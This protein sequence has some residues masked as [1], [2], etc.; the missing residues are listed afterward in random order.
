MKTW[1]FAKNREKTRKKNMDKA[2]NEKK[3]CTANA[4][5]RQAGPSHFFNVISISQQS[6]RQR[7]P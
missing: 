4:E 1:T 3:A 6:G 5:T 2:A 7:D